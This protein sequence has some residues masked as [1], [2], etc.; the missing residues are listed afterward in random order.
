[1]PYSTFCPRAVTCAIALCIAGCEHSSGAAESLQLG[2]GYGALELTA[3]VRGPRPSH[4]YEFDDGIRIRQAS[5]GCE[6]ELQLPVGRFPA[7]LYRAKSCKIER[8]SQRLCIARRTFIGVLHPE[9]A[10]EVKGCSSIVPRPAFD[11]DFQSVRQAG[12]AG[13]RPAGTATF[14]ESDGGPR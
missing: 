1:M 13:A 11:D 6:I 12:S 14:E 7:D 8:T 4:W 9:V 5:D 3:G 10:M 2:V